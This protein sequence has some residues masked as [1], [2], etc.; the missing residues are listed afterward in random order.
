M[1]RSND[2]CQKTEK[3]DDIAILTLKCAPLLH[4]LKKSNNRRVSIS[5]L[6]WVNSLDEAAHDTQVPSTYR[7]MYDTYLL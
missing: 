6:Y 1:S 5:I 7:A 3:A 2:Y 4:R